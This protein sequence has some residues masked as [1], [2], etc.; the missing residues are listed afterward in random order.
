MIIIKSKLLPVLFILIMLSGCREELDKY[1]RPE[2][3]AGKLYTQILEQ[4]ELSVFAKAIEL[5]GYDKLI[6]ISGSY[7]V[8]APSDEA[9]NTWFTNHP[10]YNSVEDIPIPELERLVRYHIIQNPWSKQQLRSLDVYGWIDTLDINNNEPKGFKRESLLFEK[11]RKYGVVRKDRIVQI[12]DTT[13]TAWH[14]RVATDSRKFAPFFFK[15]YFNIYNLTSADYEFYFNRPFS[16]GNNIHY[17][18]AVVGDEIF[19]ENGFVYVIDQ[20]VEPLKNA[21]QFVNEPNGTHSYSHFRD[22]LNIFPRFE[23]NQQKTNQ[24]A[25]ASEGLKVDSLFDLTFPQLAFDLTNEKTKPP[26]GTFGLPQNVTIRYHHGLMAPTNEAF[27]EF[28]DTYVKIPRGWGSLDG[29]PQHIKRIIANTYLSVNPIYPSDFSSGFYNGELDIVQLDPSTIIEKKFGSN[30]TFIGLNQAIVPRAFSSVTGPIYLQ[31]GYQKVMYA[32]EEAGLLPSLKRKNKNY[33]FFV[34]SDANTSLDSSLVHD[35]VTN[36]FSVFLVSPGNATRFWLN[37]NDLRTLLLN[38]IASDHPKG[39]A[40]KEFIPNLAGNY[41]IINNETG[42]V[43]GTGLTTKGYRG[44]I[45]A[46]EFPRKLSSETDNGSTYEI[47]NWFSFTSSNLF[48]R[49]STEFPQFHQLLQKAG[50]SNDKEYRY[51]FISNNENYTVFIPS[52]EAI[53][54]AKLNTLPLDELRN[55]LL[56]HFIQGDLIFTDGNKAAGYYET[57]RRDEKSSPFSTVY[58]QLYIEPGIDVIR[59]KNRDGSLFTEINESANTNRLT[60]VNIGSGQEVF[61]SI[62]NNGVLHQIDRVLIAG[63]LDTQ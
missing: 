51:T 33:M 63:E 10:A 26:T 15:E 4:P 60:G 42:E 57:I 41:I 34:E 40:R 31:Q 35:R 16:E 59:F 22:L 13:Q 36:R 19:A 37:K 20:V 1:E 45:P 2:W 5:T 62:Y 17:A 38:H 18:N 9:F 3:L 24:Q 29:A 58:T 48:T 8:F 47:Q 50:F 30:S 25:G 43:S 39:I 56:F 27:N 7:T 46:P 6:N 53:Q 12:T 14:R 49:I 61:P 54:A 55:V 44:S 23:F 11:D 28:I 21:Y 52:N 32:I